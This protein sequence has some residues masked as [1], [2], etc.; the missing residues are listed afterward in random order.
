MTPE[1]VRTWVSRQP[2]E[3]AYQECLKTDVRLSA[4]WIDWA[5]NEPSSEEIADAGL[6]HDEETQIATSCAF[7]VRCWQGTGDQVSKVFRSNDVVRASQREREMESILTQLPPSST[8][9]F[10]KTDL[11]FINAMAQVDEIEDD[12]LRAI[13]RTQL[14]DQLQENSKTRRQQLFDDIERDKWQESLAGRLTRFFKF[15]AIS[16]LLLLIIKSC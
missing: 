14:F 3:E 11:G 2:S 10:E 13:A 6:A 4:V 15:V 8:L 1:E 5:D 16:S 9:A 7:R 12:D